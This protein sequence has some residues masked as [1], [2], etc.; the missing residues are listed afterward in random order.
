MA[1]KDLAFKVGGNAVQPLSSSNNISS[2]LSIFFL[3]ILLP[4]VIPGRPTEEGE[5]QDEQKPANQVEH[6]VLGDP[7]VLIGEVDH[8]HRRVLDVVVALPDRRVDR[9]RG[10]TRGA[11][12]VATLVHRSL[13]QGAKGRGQ[14]GHRR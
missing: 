5:G 6:Q 12:V 10:H 9:D 11:D 7:A 3:R 1:V 8:H 2:K 4:S 14:E 13:H